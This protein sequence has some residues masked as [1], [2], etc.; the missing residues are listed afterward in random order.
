MNRAD[1]KRFMA[2]IIEQHKD[3]STDSISTDR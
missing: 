1:Y 2:Q 3:D